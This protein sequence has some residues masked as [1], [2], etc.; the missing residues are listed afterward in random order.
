MPVT[1]EV[2]TRILDAIIRNL[3]GNVADTIAK[4]ALTVET[5]AKLRAPVDTGA[6][7]AS[8]YTSL[9]DNDGFGEARSEAMARSTRRNGAGQIHPLGAKNFVELPKPKDNHTAYVGP[10]VEYGAAVEL[11]TAQ[12]SGTPYLQPAVRETESEFQEMLGKAVT[13]RG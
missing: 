1:T 3:G 7:R 13:N 11:G 5:K 2:D 12:R 10:S 9:K 4:V 6:L 8:I